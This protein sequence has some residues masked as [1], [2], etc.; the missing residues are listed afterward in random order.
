MRVSLLTRPPVAVDADDRA[1]SAKPARKPDPLVREASPGLAVVLAATAVSSVLALVT[2]ADP[3][4]YNVASGA[5]RGL[6]LLLF[7]LIAPGAVVLTP[8]RRLS[9]STKVATAPLFGLALL[10]GFGTVGSWTGQWV[11]RASAAIV[12]G[13]ALAWAVVY[14]FRVHVWRSPGRLVRPRLSSVALTL[15]LLAA[16]V[17][18]LVSLPGIRTAPS[19]VLGLLVAGPRTFPAAILGATAVLLVSLRGH[20]PYVSTAAVSTLVLVLRSTASVLLPVPTASWTYKHLGV[21]IAL[22]EHHHVASGADIYMNWPGMF[23]GAAYFADTSGVPVIDLARCITPLI[24]ILLALSTFAL[25]RALGAGRP[26]SIAAAGL[27]VAFNWVGQD[28]FAP[29]AIAICLAAGVVVLL[30]QSRHNLPCALLA[31]VLFSAIVVTHQLTP[32]WLL[33]LTFALVVLR[34]TPWWLALAM[35]LVTALYILTRWDVAQA[36]GLFSGF[37]PVANAASSV[38]VVPTLGREAGALF[39]KA[40]SLL[41][42]GATAVVLVVRGVRPG[43]RQFWRFWRHPDVYVQAAIAFSPVILLFGNSYGGEAILRVTLYSTPGCCV[44]LGPALVAAIRRG[45]VIPLVAAAW[46]LVTVGACAQSAY[47]LWFV[48]LIRP[49]DVAAAQWLATQHP[50]AVVLPAIAVWPGRTSVDYERF[51]GK[52][53]SLEPGLDDRIHTM[54]RFLPLS[55]T[56]L[57]PD[58]AAEVAG[59]HPD[60]TTYI[61]FTRNMRDYDQYYADFLPGAYDRTLGVL[62]SNPDWQVV[63]HQNDVWVFRYRPSAGPRGADK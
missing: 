57:I 23:A 33:V 27:V 61:V 6:F 48:D 21:V 18:W 47:S 56:P 1:G 60:K 58:L 19:S 20:H 13:V 5:F 34:R 55:S 52:L 31:F 45:V 25:A 30:V 49:E 62:P 32:F 3:S 41:M 46:T 17:L 39:A 35:L 24:H 16:V 53:T 9:R 59:I 51:I 38:P 11:P 7:W 10:I 40:S 14:A 50:R 8:L 26:G 54:D 36:Y 12:A 22:Q 43:W 4:A 37:D 28:Y 29:Q 63:R 2:L 44:I 15:A 42:W